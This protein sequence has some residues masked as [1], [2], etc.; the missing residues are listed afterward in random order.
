[1]RLKPKE[2]EGIKLGLQSALGDQKS[3]YEIYLFGSRTDDQA[4]GGDIDLL[5]LSEGSHIQELIS[6]KRKI[7]VQIQKNIGERKIDLTISS[8]NKADQD[9]FVQSI[10]PKA[11]KIK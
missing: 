8:K 11:Q 9:D 1:M 5:I 6:L 4:R 3:P 10:L 7:V 2:V